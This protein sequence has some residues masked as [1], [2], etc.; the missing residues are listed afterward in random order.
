MHV[1]NLEVSPTRGN[2]S[3]RAIFQPLNTQTMGF[4]PTVQRRPL[5]SGSLLALGGGDRGRDVRCHFHPSLAAHARARAGRTL[6]C[7]CGGSRFLGRE[8]RLALVLVLFHIFL[9]RRFFLPNIQERIG[10]VHERQRKCWIFQESQGKSTI[11]LKTPPKY[12]LYIYISISLSLSLYVYTYIY[13]Y[14][15]IHIYIYIYI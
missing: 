12:A 4:L 15:P 9:V 2:L 1:S 7:G 3:L 8:A 6:I 14:I 13:I 11:C 5:R 10:R